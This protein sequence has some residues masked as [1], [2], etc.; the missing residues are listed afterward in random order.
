M[1]ILLIEDNAADAALIKDLFLLNFC[2][3]SMEWAQTLKKG[4]EKIN[5]NKFNLI[6]LDLGL[7]DSNGMSTLHAVHAHTK[8]P[9]VI[10]TGNDQTGLGLAAVKAGAQDYL[11]K[12]TNT[13]NLCQSIDFAIERH[14]RKQVESKV[15]KTKVEYTEAIDSLKSCVINLETFL[16]QKTY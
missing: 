15:R 10:L 5:K 16:K 4:I 14:A 13:I 9:I 3:G 11:T 1:R 6:I 2:E 7:P 8:T 12:G